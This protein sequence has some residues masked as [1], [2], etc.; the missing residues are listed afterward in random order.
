MHR[1]LAASGSIRAEHRVSAIEDKG[2][3]RGAL[4]YFDT[5]LLDAARGERQASLRKA[6]QAW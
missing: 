1:L 2:P 5:E 4:L 3:R 6:V